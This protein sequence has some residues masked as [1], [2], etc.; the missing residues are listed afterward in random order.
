MSVDPSKSAELVEIV[1]RGDRLTA[2]QAAR[3][4]L[5]VEM[6]RLQTH[7]LANEAAGRDFA[8]M[9]KELSRIMAEIDE[10]GGVTESDSVDELT[11]R[12]S[13]RRKAQEG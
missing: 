6:A 5:A 7:S 1:S 8:V 12:R 10:I 3:D 13:Q 9:T 2:L 4:A 11:Q